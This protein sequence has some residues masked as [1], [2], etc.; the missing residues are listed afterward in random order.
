MLLLP[1]LK[2][3]GS[4]FKLI[5]QSGGLNSLNQPT[6]FRNFVAAAGD[7]IL[8]YVLLTY[9]NN[10]QAMVKVTATVSAL[11]AGGTTD[12]DTFHGT[13]TLNC[14]IATVERHILSAEDVEFL[15]D[16]VTE[17]NTYYGSTNTS[18][19]GG[20]IPLWLSDI[21]DKTIEDNKIYRTFEVFVAG[22]NPYQPN[23]ITKQIKMYAFAPKATGSNSLQSNNYSSITAAVENL[24]E[25]IHNNQSG[26]VFNN[27]VTLLS[28]QNN[29]PIEFSSA[30]PVDLDEW[31]GLNTGVQPF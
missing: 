16:Y 15:N 25:M 31:F 19:R 20:T 6:D 24:F 10:A 2:T 18:L 17:G 12:P 1:Y 7:E 30:M 29:N 27:L 23:L 13:I 3:D 8:S 14:N 9:Q 28:N 5:L 26:G 21:D 4:G 11:Y 22:F